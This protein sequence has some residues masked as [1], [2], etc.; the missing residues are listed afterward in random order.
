MKKLILK[1]FV[2]IQKKKS[3][4]EYIIFAIKFVQCAQMY[5]F[6]L[7]FLLLFSCFSPTSP[8][9]PQTEKNKLEKKM[10]VFFF[11]LFFFHFL[12]ESKHAMAAFICLITDA[13]ANL[14]GMN[15]V[16]DIKKLPNLFFFFALFS[17]V[18]CYC[19]LDDY[20]MEYWF[21]VFFSVI[22]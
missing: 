20:S 19:L 18:S 12:G 4:F 7:F 15:G 3:N 21:N 9:S 6:F 1:P 8:Y 17:R 5:I 10:G 11:F 14:L 22:Y 2:K 16:V 13:C